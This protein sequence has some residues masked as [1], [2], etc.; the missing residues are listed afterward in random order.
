M[1][2]ADS[3]TVRVHITAAANYLQA[4][5]G[6]AAFAG[7]ALQR[8]QALHGL[9]QGSN[10]SIT[11]AADIVNDVRSLPFPAASR[12]LVL[13]A[14][15]THGGTAARSGLQDYGAVVGYYPSTF[16]VQLLTT[17]PSQVNQ[18]MHVTIQQPCKLGLEHSSEGT[19][20]VITAITLVAAEGSAK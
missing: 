4:L 3:A 13:S 20:A 19:V 1:A 16:W 5:Q 14:I 10:F 18:T 9:L 17:D 2:S 11:D 12:D 8:T 7:A 6:T 15:A